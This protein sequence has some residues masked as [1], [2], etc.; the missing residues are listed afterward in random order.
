MNVWSFGMTNYI[1][2]WIME[3]VAKLII[4]VTLWR[5]FDLVSHVTG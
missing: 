1:G 3:S 2:V 5:N 4:P